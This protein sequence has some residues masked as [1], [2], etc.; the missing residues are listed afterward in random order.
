MINQHFLSACS[1]SCSTKP[2]C[3]AVNQLVHQSASQF[4]IQPTESVNQTVSSQS[5][6][7]LLRQCLGWSNNL[8]LLICYIHPASSPSP[9]GDVAVYVF[10]YKTSSAWL[11]LFILL[12]VSLSVITAL[13]TVLCS[14]NLPATLHFL[15]LV[16]FLPFN[17]ISLFECLPKFLVKKQLLLFF[18]WPL[19]RS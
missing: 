8:W 3:P 15:P 6:T 13:S 16:L 7:C 17:F 19:F 12:L 11:L 2:Y 10:W 14:I 9:G 1:V 4:I 18:L 5:D